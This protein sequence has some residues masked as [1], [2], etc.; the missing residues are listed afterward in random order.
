MKKRNSSH[1]RGFTLIEVLVVMVILGVLMLIGLPILRSFLLRSQMVAF[2]TQLQSTIQ[3]ARSEAVKQG[4]P[5]VVQL[6]PDDNRIRA[7][8]DIPAFDGT[9]AR[10]DTPLTFE[11]EVGLLAPETD[12]ILF[13]VR[14]PNAVILGSPVGEDLIDGMT[15]I[16]AGPPETADVSERVL[17]FNPNG[18]AGA[19]GAFRFAAPGESKNYLE[20]EVEFV[21]TGK[22][23][24][25]KWDCNDS[26]WRSRNDAVSGRPAWEWYQKFSGS[27]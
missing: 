21:S 24:L 19:L 2:G 5:V 16:S 27:C 1:R 26:V 6:Q 11:P 4:F 15:N 25:K 14:F 20:A 7:Y 10:T 22:T 17:V 8:V 3:R 9:G 12:R 18:S 23:T 13:E